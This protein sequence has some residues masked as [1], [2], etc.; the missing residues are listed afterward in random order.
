MSSGRAYR[1]FSL[2]PT[3][4]RNWHAKANSERV[5]RSRDQP[6]LQQVSLWAKR[7]GGG[8]V[9][10]RRRDYFQ[11][12]LQVGG[13]FPVDDAV[14]EIGRDVLHGAVGAGQGVGDEDVQDAAGGGHSHLARRAQGS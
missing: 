11:P 12:Y 3:Q 8:R 14:V 7:K 4:N 6:R 13:D 5:R 9:T 2:K 10:E 1:K